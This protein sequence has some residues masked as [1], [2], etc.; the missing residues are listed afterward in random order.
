MSAHEPADD[1][2]EEVWRAL[3][4]V[5]RRQLL[6][7]LAAGP[8]TTGEL[9]QAVP[10]LSRFAVMQHLAV[11]AG[12]GLVLVRRRGRHRYNHLNPVPL[13]RWYERWVRPLADRTAAELLA[14]ER[15]VEEA[16][17]G[18]TVS[19]AIHE[20]RTVR[21]ETELRFRAP[22]RR[23]FEALTG[24]TRTW[25]PSTYGGERVRAVVMEPRVGGMHYEDW[26][27]GNGHLYGQVVAWDPPG[28]WAT[29]G[30]IMPGTI[31]DTEYS[32]EE[33]D[34]ESVLRVAKVAVGPMTEEEAAG[35]RRFGDI[36]NFEDALRRFIEAAGHE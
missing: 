23:V 35:V 6:D 15:H 20:L 27:D 10:G 34:G 28:A 8:R 29:R 19:T 36:A 30:R 17:G 16:R 32:L 25:F 4:N 3:A 22:A 2:H 21:I 1:A 24:D 9:A 12:A 13:R 33:A 14:L 26:G 7:I 11:L 5:T 31:L 18:T